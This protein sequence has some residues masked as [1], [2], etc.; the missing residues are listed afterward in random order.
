[1]GV[2]ADGQHCGSHAP[3]SPAAA[4]SAQ[5]LA[6]ELVHYGFVHEVRC[7]GQVRPAWEGDRVGRAPPSP[8]PPSRP[9]GRS[10]EAGCLPGQHLPQVPWSSAVTLIRAPQGLKPP[11]S[12]PPGSLGKLGIGLCSWVGNQGLCLPLCLLVRTSPRIAPCS[13]GVGL[14]VPGRAHRGEGAGAGGQ[15]SCCMSLGAGCP[16]QPASTISCPCG[17]EGAAPQGTTHSAGG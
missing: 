10:A 2:G 3:A 16:V 7:A 14:R 8:M 4:D 6:A 1:M 13:P 12:R 17:H 15:V 5:D 9:A 11:G